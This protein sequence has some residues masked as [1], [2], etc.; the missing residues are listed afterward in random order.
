MNFP[1]WLAILGILICL[2][3]SYAV[4]AQRGKLRE[5][6]I[7][8]SVS[9]PSISETTEPQPATVVVAEQ[10]LQP[11]SDT[12]TN[13]STAESKPVPT[14]LLRLRSQVTLLRMRKRELESV[15]QENQRL[16]LPAAHSRSNNDAM[17]LPPGFIRKSEARFAGYQTP[18]ATIE[19]LVWSL[20]QQDVTNLL[21]AFS[22][23]VAQ[24]IQTE[25]LSS[26]NFFSGAAAIPGFAIQSRSNTPD[27]M[28]DLNVIVAPGIPAQNLRLKLID[29]EWKVVTP[30]F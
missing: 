24:K 12:N 1:R 3:A 22:A 28:V 4:F 26:S 10:S 19:S 2:A 23:D 9:G 29:G 17:E 20:A 15:E 7:A 21:K 27:G 30:N 6:R 5:L 11:G 18:E 25:V 8:A 14:E 16:Q 13:G